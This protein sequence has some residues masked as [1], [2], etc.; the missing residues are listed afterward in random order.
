MPAFHMDGALGKVHFLGGSHHHIWLGAEAE[1]K[2]DC[3]EA[4]ANGQYCYSYEA[5][6]FNDNQ[7]ANLAVPFEKGG[8]KRAISY[9]VSL[10]NEKI[11][12]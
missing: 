6:F 11:G 5:D 8:V 12:E 1:A 9:A 3:L 4:L 7:A 2:Q 10:L